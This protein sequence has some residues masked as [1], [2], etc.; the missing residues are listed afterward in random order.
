MKILVIH[1]S[2]GAGHLKA[3]ESLHNGIKSTTQ[4][5]VVLLDA[6]DHSTPYFKELYKGTYFFL[7]SKIPWLWGFFFWLLDVVWL[8]PLIRFVRRLYNR[9][10]T[11]KLHRYMKEER[12]DIIFS[13]HFMPTEVAASLKRSKQI[14]AKLITI[15]TDFDVHKIW[16]AR[17]VDH[18]CVAS[19]WTKDK[20]IKLGIATESVL[21]SGIPTDEKFSAPVDIGSLKEKLGLRENIFTVLIA[22]GAFGIGPI[23]EVINVLAGFQVIVVCGHNEDL[24]KRLG[25]KKNDLVKVLPLVDNMHELMAVSDAMVTKP[26]GLSISEALV[27]QLSLIFFNA[28]PG[29]ETGNIKVLKK[30]E[31]GIS[32]CSVSQIGEELVRLKFSRDIFLTTLKKTKALAR[33]GAVRD[34]ISLIK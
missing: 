24:Y 10:N 33:P 26:G 9:A 2:A 20:I 4:H 11:G 8:Q 29:Q 13:T 15:I 22:T 31:I 12:F 17:G 7:I 18:Y 3:A 32:G 16:L 27:S 30:H 25:S 34:I 23:E 28:I 5:D 19:D 6:L 14:T 21:A 1:A